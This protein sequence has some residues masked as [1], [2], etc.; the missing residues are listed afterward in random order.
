MELQELIRTRRSIRKYRGEQIPREALEK[1]VEAGLYAP[2]AGG[3]Q[4]TMI[5]AVRDRALTERLGRL[6]LARF[7][8]SR[9]LGSYVSKEQPSVIDD[10]SI[11]SGFYGAYA[12]FLR[13]KTFCSAS[14]TH[15][16]PRRTWYCR[17][18]SWASP[19]A[20]FRAGRRH[21]RARRGSNFCARGKYPKITSRGA[22]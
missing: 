22:S 2:S 17:R 15:S 14:P 16:A 5:V 10:A 11:R 21:S 3:R 4:G 18:R 19:R 1:I 7:D 20:S 9:L 8:R 12:R 13:R 6:N